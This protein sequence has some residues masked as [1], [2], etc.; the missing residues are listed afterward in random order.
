MSLH[1]LVT[2]FDCETA[3]SRRLTARTG[4]RHGHV[5]TLASTLDDTRLNAT[6][7]RSVDVCSSSTGSPPRCVTENSRSRRCEPFDGVIA[8]G[9]CQSYDSWSSISKS[10]P[11]NRPCPT[12]LRPCCVM[13]WTYRRTRIRPCRSRRMCDRTGSAHFL[14][15]STRPREP[16]PR[17]DAY[18]FA[19]RNS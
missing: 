14:A 9:E 12:R 18:R 8:E 7:L 13:R 1:A 6:L 15:T 4:C 5:T 17:R 2:R 19:A 11:C 3:V 16:R 10:P